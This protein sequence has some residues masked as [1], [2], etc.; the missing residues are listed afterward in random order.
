MGQLNVSSSQ[1][2]GHPGEP[3]KDLLHPKPI[4]R[5]VK[6]FEP[7]NNMIRFA[8]LVITLIDWGWGGGGSD[9]GRRL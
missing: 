8:F 5:S 4:I 9:G 1:G 7:K 2:G 6:D 3:W